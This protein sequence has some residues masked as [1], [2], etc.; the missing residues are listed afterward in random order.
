MADKYRS[1]F[2]EGRHQGT[3]YSA[4]RILSIVLDAVP[5]VRSAIDFGCGVG[6]WLSVLKENGVTDIT[7][8]DGAWVKKELLQISRESFQQVDFEKPIEI[9][10]RYDLAISLEVAEHLQPRFAGR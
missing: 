5:R 8:M 9:G 4:Q 1:R 6:T 10:R 2:Y 3:S 7:G